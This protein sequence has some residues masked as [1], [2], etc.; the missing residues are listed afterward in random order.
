MSSVKVAVRVRPFNN[1]E[2][3]RECKCIIEMEDKTTCKSKLLGMI[4]LDLRFWDVQA[5]CTSPFV[6]SGTVVV[7]EA[8]ERKLLLQE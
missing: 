8:P 7:Y 6:H 3:S 4:A 5:Y 2:I 1:R